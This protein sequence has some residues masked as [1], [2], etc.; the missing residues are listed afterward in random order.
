MTVPQRDLRALV[1]SGPGDNREELSV[2][3]DDLI[4]MVNAFASC[5]PF[6]AVTGTVWRTKE[7]QNEI[8]V[9]SIII[10]AFHSFFSTDG[11]ISKF[12]IQKHFANDEITA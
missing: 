2:F 8:V 3:S 5:N 6:S 1:H 10:A 4:A 7:G 9:A 12:C 11:K